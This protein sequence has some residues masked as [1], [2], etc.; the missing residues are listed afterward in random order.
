MVSHGTWLNVGTGS[1]NFSKVVYHDKV[2]AGGRQSK[3][4]FF[5]SGSRLELKVISF[6]FQDGGMGVNTFRFLAIAAVI[7]GLVVLIA[8]FCTML[9][10]DESWWRR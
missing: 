9:R 1:R 7:F 3:F 2:G 6:S 10:L 4:I 8:S 5:T